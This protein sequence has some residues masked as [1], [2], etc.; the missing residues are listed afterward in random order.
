MMES[1]RELLKVPTNYRGFK[2]SNSAER[3]KAEIKRRWPGQEKFYNPMATTRTAAAWRRIGYYINK[4]ETG[5]ASPVI[6]EETD[7]DGN[8]ISKHVRTIF[9]FHLNQVSRL[10]RQ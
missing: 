10:K 1:I 9:L 8:V 3:V 2:D 6:I 7:D 5:I 4:N